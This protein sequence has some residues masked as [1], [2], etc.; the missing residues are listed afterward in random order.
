LLRRFDPRIVLGT[1]LSRIVAIADVFDAMTTDRL[2][3]AAH[4][5]YEAMNYLLRNTDQ[6]FD[7]EI[8][9]MFLRHPS[10]YPPGYPG[11]AQHRPICHRHQSQPELSSAPGGETGE[12]L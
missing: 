5:P 8:L 4:S 6:R 3:R 7:P 12:N 1:F 2:F 11:S 10:L 9:H